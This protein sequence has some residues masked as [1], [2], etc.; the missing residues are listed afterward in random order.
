M[1]TILQLDEIASDFTAPS[2]WANMDDLAAE[3]GAIF[4]L[5]GGIAGFAGMGASWAASAAART[6]VSQLILSVSALNTD[7]LSRLPKLR[8]LDFRLG[9]TTS[10]IPAIV[11]QALFTGKFSI[12]ADEDLDTEE[13]CA[14]FADTGED[15]LWPWLGSQWVDGYCVRL[16]RYID[17][18][19]D[20]GRS[21]C[22]DFTATQDDYDKLEDKYGFDMNEYYKSALDC[23]LNKGEDGVPDVWDLSE[24]G[25]FPRC[26]FGIRVWKGIETCSPDDGGYPTCSVSYSDF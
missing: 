17:N 14:D 21:F 16:M 12:F 26:W 25:A 15:D 19:Q 18:S 2:N 9:S 6:G 3:M 13:R 24:D 11:D 1:H 7:G 22:S 5:I 23:T 10:T 4:Y 20:C 8:R